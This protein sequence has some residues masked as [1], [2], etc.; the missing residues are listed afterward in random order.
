MYNHS[1]RKTFDDVENTAVDP[2]DEQTIWDLRVDEHGHIIDRNLIKWDHV[3]FLGEVVCPD[4]DVGE[5]TDG[6]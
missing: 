6:Q 1:G 4:T 2:A 5:D 3:L